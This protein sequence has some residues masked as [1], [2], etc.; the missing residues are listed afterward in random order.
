MEQNAVPLG[1]HPL[2]SGHHFNRRD[3]C[4]KPTFTIV[5]ALVHNF[6]SCSICFLPQPFYLKAWLEINRKEIE[7]AV[8]IPGGCTWLLSPVFRKQEVSHAT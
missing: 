8:L 5:I 2:D 4:V 1:G 3:H 7:G 6:L